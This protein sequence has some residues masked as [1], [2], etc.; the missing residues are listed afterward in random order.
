MTIQD[1]TQG[2]AR[3]EDAV[4]QTIGQGFH[5]SKFFT[6][7]LSCIIC[8][9]ERSIIEVICELSTLEHHHYQGQVPTSSHQH[10]V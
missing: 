3:I 10:L 2:I 9:E 4:E 7:G 5:M 6:L 8:Q 1:D